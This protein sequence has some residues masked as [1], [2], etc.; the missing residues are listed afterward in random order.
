MGAIKTYH[1]LPEQLDPLWLLLGRLWDGDRA[2]TA[3]SKGIHVYMFLDL[4]GAKMALQG[5][6]IKYGLQE[7]FWLL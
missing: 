4:R 7:P 3:L 6:P 5:T 2:R 1:S